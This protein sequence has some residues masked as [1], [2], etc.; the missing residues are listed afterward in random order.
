MSDVKRLVDQINI[1]ISKLV[2][3]KQSLLTENENLQKKQEEFLQQIESKNK[4][5]EELKNKNEILTIAK[6]V[7]QPEGNSDVKRKIDEMV[8][9][10][11]KC[12]EL[13]NK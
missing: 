1:K 6:K 10:V 4:I 5:I 7:K 11:D 13:L 8:R 3:I 12:I 2:E 9:E